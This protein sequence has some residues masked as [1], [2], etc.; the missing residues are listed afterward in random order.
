M[1]CSI[2]DIFF[3]EPELHPCVYHG[4]CAAH[5]YY[6]RLLMRPYCNHVYKLVV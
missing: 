6:M 5:S 2:S 1:S 3:V 4:G